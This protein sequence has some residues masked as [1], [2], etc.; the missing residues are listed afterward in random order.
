[1][2][3]AK[4]SDE[5]KILGIPEEKKV[6]KNIDYE[7]PK[8]QYKVTNLKLKNTPIV[9]TGD[10]VETFIGQ[11]NKEAREALKDGEKSVITKDCNGEKEYKIE[12]L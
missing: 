2:A 1:M 12:V 5:D 8:M 6:S 7:N 9:V 10:L 4:Q 3:K 11:S